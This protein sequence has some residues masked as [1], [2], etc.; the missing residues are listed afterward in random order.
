M[1]LNNVKPT[2]LPEAK[3]NNK[4]ANN[5]PINSGVIIDIGR[6]LPELYPAITNPDHIYYSKIKLSDS[7]EIDLMLYEEPFLEQHPKSITVDEIEDYGFKIEYNDGGDTNHIIEFGDMANKY[8][9]YVQENLEQAIKTPMLQQWFYLEKILN[10]AL[11]NKLK[12]NLDFFEI[13]NEYLA[14]VTLHTFKKQMPGVSAAQ[15]KTAVI[16]VVNEYFNFDKHYA[17]LLEI[18]NLPADFSVIK[19]PAEELAKIVYKK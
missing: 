11:A 13:R 9:K 8:L 2:N 10:P 17:N 12:L 15:F 18:A 16:D 14:H 3:S 1:R 4:P 6:V 19:K 7:L 5:K